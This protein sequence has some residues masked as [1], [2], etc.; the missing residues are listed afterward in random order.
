METGFLDFGFF[1]KR[2]YKSEKYLRINGQ[3]LENQYEIIRI[4]V[5]IM[6]VHRYFHTKR[7]KDVSKKML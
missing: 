4:T 3:F 6:K 2:P 5:Q 1:C 7:M